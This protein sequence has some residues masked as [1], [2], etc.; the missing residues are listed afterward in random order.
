MSQGK[1]DEALW[2]ESLLAPEPEPV[3][4]EPQPESPRRWFRFLRRAEESAPSR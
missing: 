1:V 3:E 2:L 4:A